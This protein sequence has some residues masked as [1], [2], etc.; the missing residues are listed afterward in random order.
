MK[1]KL[2]KI[3]DLVDDHSI[4]AFCHFCFFGSLLLPLLLSA[5]TKSN[6]VFIPSLL[7]LIPI[8]F[9]IVWF[10]LA[11]IVL[12]IESLIIAPIEFVVYKLGIPKIKINVDVIWKYQQ[13]IEDCQRTQN[14]NKQDDNNPDEVYYQ[15]IIDDKKG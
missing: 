5:F 2:Y 4:G 3:F 15:L 9:F 14:D 11:L 10:I 8:L 7:L 12:G 6:L 1:E 13:K